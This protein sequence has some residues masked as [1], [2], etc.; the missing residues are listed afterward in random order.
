MPRII[1]F[2]I[3][4]AIVFGSTALSGGSAGVSSE[5]VNGRCMVSASSSLYGIICGIILAL[6]TLLFPRNQFV[7]NTVGVVGLWR[8]FGAFFIDFIVVLTIVTPIAALPI[9]VTESSYIG[10][11]QWA[12]SRDFSRASDNYYILPTVLGIFVILFF[13]FYHQVKNGQQTL[14][15]YVLNYKVS[16]TT[17]SG[18]VPQYAKRIFFSYIGLCAWPISVILALRSDNKACWWDKTT[19]TK[20][21]KGS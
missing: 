10:T 7:E 1:V 11:F 4:M 16:S 9:L 3:T 6:F 20:L 12:F 5:C 21:V 8:R 14:G 19:N 18:K 17:Q 15:Q 13:Y 2:I